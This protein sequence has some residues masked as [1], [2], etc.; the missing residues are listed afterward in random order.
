MIGRLGWKIFIGSLLCLIALTKV[1]AAEMVTIPHTEVHTL[2]SQETGAKYQIQIR[3]PDT[4]PPESGFPV[5]YLLDSNAWFGMAS[6][7]LSSRSLNRDSTGVAPAILVGIA[8]PTDAP[9]DL[10]RRTFDLT[11]PAESVTLPPRPNGKPW[12]PT[13][14]ADA[15]LSF[16]EAQ[17]KP[18]IDELANVDRTQETLMGH[19]FGGLFALHVMLTH[20]GAFDTYLAGS[21]SIWFNQR[22]T[23]REAEAYLAAECTTTARL[24][25]CV[26]GQEEDITNVEESHRQAE[27]RRRWKKENRMI[28]NAQDFVALMSNRPELDVEFKVFEGEDHGT[29]IPQL[30]IRGLQFAFDR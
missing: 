15:F 8:Y 18:L 29:I 23:M 2:I 3:V 4:A 1:Q 30:M 12:P 17:V 22:Q 14:G 26:G 28:G 11:P 21:P 6:D 5:I 9:Y 10:T 27:T 25:L 20:P 16:I 24:Y 19:S 7:L 13:G